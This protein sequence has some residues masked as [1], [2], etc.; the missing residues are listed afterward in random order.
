MVIPGEI[1]K[2][3][4]QYA[5]LLEPLGAYGQGRTRKAACDALARTVRDFAADYGPLAGFD[6]Q[7]TDGGEDTIYVTSNDPARLLSLLLRRQREL[8]ELSLADVAKAMGNKS[9]NGFA[10]Y[11]TGRSE[12]SITKLQELLDAVAP[13]LAVAI[14]PRTARVVPCW[15]EEMENAAEIN[16]VVKDPSAANVAALRA[17][18]IAR[19]AVKKAG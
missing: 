6:V 5:A 1:D 11:E 7:V 2:K 17:K 19:R 8:H 13:E 18:A 4:S 14:V 16:A 9:R 12:P 3:G 15:D 10:Q